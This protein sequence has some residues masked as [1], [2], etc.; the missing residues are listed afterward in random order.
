MPKT[1]VVCHYRG[2]PLS[3]YATIVAYFLCICNWCKR[4]E[5]YGKCMAIPEGLIANALKYTILDVEIMKEKVVY[6]EF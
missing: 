3:W 1:I 4:Y 6:D 2:M 5:K